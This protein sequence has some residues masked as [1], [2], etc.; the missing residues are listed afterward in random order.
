MAG[1]IRDAVRLFDDKATK[2][3]L[4]SVTE[5]KNFYIALS[6]KDSVGSEVILIRRSIVPTNLQ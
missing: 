6:T 1:M 5:V 3:K 2:R 4:E